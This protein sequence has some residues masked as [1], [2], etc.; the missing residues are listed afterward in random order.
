MSDGSCEYADLGYDCDGNF[1][2]YVVGME[3][4]GGIVF[5][6]DETGEHGLVAAMEDLEG[7]LYEM[8]YVM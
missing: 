3:A 1:V 7:A 8:G 2:E 6:V 4:E 5:Y